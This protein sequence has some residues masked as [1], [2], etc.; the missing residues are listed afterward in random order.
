MG[1]EIEI[2]DLL[3]ARVGAFAGRPYQA[4]QREA[5]QQD[6][7]LAPTD[8]SCDHL[9]EFELPNAV[10]MPVRLSSLL[11]RGPLALLLFRGCW[12]EHDRQRIAL[13]DSLAPALSEIGATCISLSPAVPIGC[14]IAAERTQVSLD[15]ISDVGSIISRR[16]VHTK[17]VQPTALWGLRRLGVDVSR[18]YGLER[19]SFPIPSIAA[20]R[21]DAKVIYFRSFGP[22]DA[23]EAP[24]F[25]AMFDAMSKA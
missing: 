7:E 17:V 6:P 1:L 2:C 25:S 4:L 16:L 15:I 24:C 12:S 19:P 8:A 13:L 10:G 22:R 14:L 5:C 23:V 18:V 11:R 21:A 9:E 3:E 20:I